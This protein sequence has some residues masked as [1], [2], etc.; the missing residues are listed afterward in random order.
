MG[1]R[2]YSRRIKQVNI[3]EHLGKIIWH[4]PFL[5]FSSAL[6]TILIVGYYLIMLIF[7][8]ALA[9]IRLPKCLLIEYKVRRTTWIRKKKLKAAREL[10]K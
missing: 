4:V 2:D 9:L 7:P 8:L 5:G 3:M 6:G 1:N 10:N